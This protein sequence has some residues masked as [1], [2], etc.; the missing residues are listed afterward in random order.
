M[1]SQKG[2][3]L[4]SLVITIIILIILAGVSIAIIFDNDGIITKSKQAAENM[5]IA[6][7]EEQEMLNELYDKLENQGTSVGSSGIEA[8][9]N[10]LKTEYENYKTKVAEALT[11]KG[12][13]ASKNDD[14]ETIAT[15]INSI[16]SGSSVYYLGTGT[17]FDIKTKFPDDYANLTADNFIVKKANTSDISGSSGAPAWSPDWKCNGGGGDSIVSMSQSYNA[18]TGIFNCSMT[19][20]ARTYLILNQDGGPRYGGYISTNIPVSVYLVL[21]EIKNIN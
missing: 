1:K 19:L 11:S 10:S 8:K 9:Y 18:S 15:S 21:G 14:A 17:S 12:I 7:I 4:I 2:I 5:Q 16:Q 13:E 20:K 6:A 3:T